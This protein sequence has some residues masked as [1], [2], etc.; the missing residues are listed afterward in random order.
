MK[1]S[2]SLRAWTDINALLRTHKL[3]NL[4]LVVVCTLQVFVIGWM[5]A[6]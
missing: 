2:N 1:K 4:G 6:S 3:I 5:Y